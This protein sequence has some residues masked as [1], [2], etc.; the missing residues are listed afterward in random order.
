MNANDEAASL[1]EACSKPKLLV[2]LTTAQLQTTEIRSLL[3]THVV[4][5]QAVQ[6][7]GNNNETRSSAASTSRVFDKFNRQQ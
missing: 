4:T 3:H 2:D 1:F 7:E 6:D 5:R